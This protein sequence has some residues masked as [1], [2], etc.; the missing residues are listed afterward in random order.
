MKVF[1][2]I[3]QVPDTESKIKIRADQNGI[4]SL[5]IKWVMN[6]YDE[7]AVEEALKLREAGKCTAVH[8]I[9]L[10]PK[11]R[12][13]ETLRTALAMGA[14]EALVIDSGEDLDSSATA[15]ALAAA[16]K[17]EGE[18]KFI[19]TGK[20]AIDDNNSAVSQMLAEFLNLPHATVVS[21]MNVQEA[22]V[23]CEREIEAGTREVIELSIPALI[24]AN[25][26]L[27]T[28]RYASL[29]GIMKA[30]KKLIKEV[31]LESLGVGAQDIKFKF[32]AFQLPPEKPSVKM[33]TG[34]AKQQVEQLAGLL[35]NEAKVI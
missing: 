26:G 11:S 18:F 8:V 22:N 9:S 27:N 5:G 10:G 19:L 4:D 23:L 12:V 33:L 28:P 20:L 3:K 34:D 31:T 32:V 1:V 2:C 24:A 6:P 25:K 16:I 17:A 21:K 7:Y 13:T 29:P 14:D 15:K 30:K 35:R